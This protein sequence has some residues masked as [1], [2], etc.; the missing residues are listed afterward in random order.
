MGS[1]AIDSLLFW[2]DSGLNLHRL[3]SDSH[4][5][6]VPL[7][8]TFS[9]LFDLK[10]VNNTLLVLGAGLNESSTLLARIDRSGVVL[11]SVPLE[12]GAL[13]WI[14]QTQTLQFCGSHSLHQASLSVVS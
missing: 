10:S 5:Q 8:A 2:V 4:H 11:N 1:V 6:A 14:P 13:A 3:T 12:G 7:N 9:K